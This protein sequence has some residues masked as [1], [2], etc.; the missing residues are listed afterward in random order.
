MEVSCDFNSRRSA[1]LSAGGPMIATSQPLAA[2]AGMRALRDGGTAADAAVAAAAAL[3]VTEPCSIG[4]GGDCFALYYRAATGQVSALNASGRAPAALNLEALERGGFE[5]GAGKELPVFHAH[6]V[7]VPGACAGWFELLGRYG[8]LPRARALAPAIELAERGFPVSPLTSWQWAQ[9]IHGQLGQDTGGQALLVSGRAPE[10]GQVFE[11]PDQAAV[12]RALAEEGPGAF[13]EGRIAEAIVSLVQRRGGLLS[14]EDMRGHRCTWGEAICV[15]YH[16]LRLWEHPPNGQGIAALL[17]L[18]TLAG[19]EL[20]ELEALGAERVHLVLEALRLAFGDARWHVRDPDVPSSTGDPIPLR[21]LLSPE[22]GATRRQLID[23]QRAQVSMTHQRPLP[24]S[25]TAYLCVV[26]GEGNAC[27]FIGSNYMGFGTGLV[28]EG[29]GFTL[30][31]RGHGFPLDREHPG[32]LQPRARP[33][34]T[35]IPGLLTRSSD[36]ALVGPF[37]VMGGFMQPQGHVQVV[38]GLVHDDLDAQQVLDRPRFRIGAETDGT[39]VFLEQ[40]YPAETA[41]KLRQLGHSVTHNLG[42]HARQMFGR[43]QA[44]LRRNPDEDVWWGGSDPR[45]DGCVLI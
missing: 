33:Y 6:T 39:S 9:G 2:W 4:L 21:E 40:G 24:S 8:K 36:D 23:R 28:P 37:G 45:A 35:I 18:N 22:F 44:I 11:N 41:E 29:C 13:Y 25:D 20:G 14:L 5:V 26:D 12:L 17:A 27:S 1:V 34:H 31:N 32:A 3:G 15:D 30:H 16:G 38:L 19:F 10:P 7:T 43:G 42:G